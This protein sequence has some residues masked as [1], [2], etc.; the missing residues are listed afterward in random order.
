L[1]R[2]LAGAAALAAVLTV[3]PGTASAAPS[4]GNGAE[5]ILLSCGGAT[6][7]I[8]TNSGAS[9]WEVDAAREPTGVR[10]FATSIEARFYQGQLATEPTGVDPVFAFAK[11]WGNRTGHGGSIACTFTETMTDE[12]GTFTGF[13]DVT[14]TARDEGN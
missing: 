6:V 3:A 11:E 8:I 1:R 2:L 7:R 4:K 5:E 12:T 10:Y 14:A 13:F 9:A